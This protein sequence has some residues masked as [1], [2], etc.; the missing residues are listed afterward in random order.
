MKARYIKPQ[1]TVSDIETESFLCNSI[2]GNIQNEEIS[3]TQILSKDVKG[4]DIWGFD[5]DED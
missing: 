4:Y 5:D 1:M 2:E 3:G